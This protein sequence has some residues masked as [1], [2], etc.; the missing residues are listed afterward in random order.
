[1]THARA[2]VRFEA[3]PKK[4]LLRSWNR[5]QQTAA[6]RIF[7]MS[8]DIYDDQRFTKFGALAMMTCRWLI[9]RRTW[10]RRFGQ[11]LADQGFPILEPHV[12]V[13]ADSSG[14][15]P[16]LLRTRVASRS[17]PLQKSLHWGIGHPNHTREN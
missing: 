10:R 2:K 11:Y 17:M 9:I 12:D 5:R 14:G 3:T 8:P 16:M 15:A 6:L 7:S 4:Q 13:P 1:M